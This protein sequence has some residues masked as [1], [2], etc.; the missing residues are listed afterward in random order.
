MS[1]LRPHGRGLYE[2][3]IPVHCHERKLLCISLAQISF[4]FDKNS[5]SKLNFWTFEWLG[6]NLPN[7]SNLVWNQESVFLQTLHHPSVSWNI[8]LPYFFISIFICFRQK[9]PIKVEFFRHSLARLKI[10]QIHYVILQVTSRFSFKFCITLQ[11]HGTSLWNFLAETLYALDQKSSSTNNFSDFECCNESSP[12]SS[13]RFWDHMVAVYTNFASLF[14]VMK[15]NSC[16]FLWLNTSYT[17]DKSSP[18]KWNFWNFEWLGEN[19]PNSSCLVWNQ[20]SVFLQT[21]HYCSVSWN[22]ILLYFFM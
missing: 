19:S 3:C 12:N 1:F 11:C 10:S 17:L 9:N 14:S 18:W 8:I 5:R 6:E 2:F 16:L 21:L 22:V 20:E 7:S 13:Y 4:N 15:D